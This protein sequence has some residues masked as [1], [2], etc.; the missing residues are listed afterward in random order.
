MT[1]APPPLPGY[2]I[3][4]PHDPFEMRA[5]P[6]FGSAEDGGPPRFALRLEARHCN[7]GGTAHGGLLMSMADLAL[8]A[9]AVHDLPEE[10]AITV[11]FNAE[12]VDAG[13]TGEVV[14]ARGEIVRRT[15][16]MVFVKG[17]IVAGE[18]V[19]LTCSAVVKRTPRLP[20]T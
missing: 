11:A 7:S 14:E 20:R 2:A 5:G 8:C 9:A 18:R 15:R 13:R 17:E 4:D 19:L 1:D 12:F 16:G 10:R 3:Y 6:F